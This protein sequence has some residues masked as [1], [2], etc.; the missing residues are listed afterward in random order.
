MNHS[1]LSEIRNMDN[2]WVDILIH[3]CNFSAEY[4]I[5]WSDTK[6]Y[7]N[8]APPRY[9]YMRGHFVQTILKMTRQNFD[10]ILSG[11]RLREAYG[12]THSKQTKNF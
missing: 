3:I 10:W 1:E 5:K 4:K 8:I 11:V 2:E 12:I 9:M 7:L 6:S